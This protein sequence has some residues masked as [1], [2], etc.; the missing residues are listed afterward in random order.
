MQ[1]QVPDEN[2]PVTSA[3][4]NLTGLLGTAALVESSFRPPCRATLRVTCLP[5]RDIPAQAQALVERM[6]ATP[7]S[8]DP[9]P[10]KVFLP[11]AGEMQGL[12][13][14]SACL[15]PI[16]KGL[17]GALPGTP[18]RGWL[19]EDKVER[20]VGQDHRPW[21][22]YPRVGFPEPSYINTKC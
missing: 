16:F 2:K 8:T 14:P 9:P 13:I 15:R 4:Q 5:S 12:M 22:L 3:E 20:G 17:T 7:V 11:L 10:Q 19:Q 6:K 1:T 18:P 21:A